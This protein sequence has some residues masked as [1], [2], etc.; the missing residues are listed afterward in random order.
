[1]I[2][3]LQLRR[4]ARLRLGERVRA[5][6]LAPHPHPVA[7]RLGG[8]P[9]RAPEED[10]DRAAR[11]HRP[12]QQSGA[13]GRRDRDARHAGAGTSRRRPAARARRTK[14]MTYDLNPAEARERTDE[15]HGADPQGV[16]GA[17]AV[18]LAGPPLPVPDDLHLA[19]PAAAAASAD[20]LARH[21]PRVL[22][23]RRAPPPRLRRVLRPVRGHGEVDALLP[24]AV[25]APRLDAGARA[26]RLSR[27]HARGGHRRG[28][29]RAARAAAEAGA[30]RD[31]CGSPR[32]LHDA[33]RAQ[34][35]RREADAERRRRAC[36]PRSSAAPTRSSSR[37]AAVATR[38]ARACSICRFI[39]PG[40]G[41]VEPLHARARAVRHESPAAHPGSSEDGHGLHRT[42]RR[43]RR[44]PHP[45]HGGAGRE[46][47]SSTCTAPAACASR[48]RTSCSPASSA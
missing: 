2:E 23:V 45:L 35:R 10:H 48:R 26:D 13:R 28:G 18:R 27:E 16:D 42:L 44:L 19:A 4:G 12:A 38:S 41:E 14:S 3:R 5:S 36:P 32:R 43:R 34:H 47:R 24:R 15:G 30:V 21:Q 1:M 39:P 9:R 40:S 29:A 20:V 25:R 33:R 37:C 22:R 6:L 11:P 8:V 46:R 17:A 31:A 7:D